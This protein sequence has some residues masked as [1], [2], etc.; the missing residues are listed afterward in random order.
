MSLLLG[1]QTVERARQSLIDQEI[2]RVNRTIDDLQVVTSLLNTDVRLMVGLENVQSL[3]AA[4]A[5]DADAQTLDR[6]REETAQDFLALA[7]T[8]LFYDQLR[9]VDVQGNELVRVEADAVGAEPYVVTQLDNIAQTVHFRA[10]IGLPEGN[11]Y[12]SD[13]EITRE[14]PQR[15]IVLKNGR[16][17]PVVRYSTPV[18]ALSPTTNARRAVGIVLINI[19]ADELFRA[20][21]PNDPGVEQ[22]YLLNRDGYFLYHSTKPEL[23]FGFEPGI[24]ELGLN[25]VGG[26]ATTIRAVLPDYAPAY[27]QAEAGLKSLTARLDGTDYLSY[28]ARVRPEGAPESYY[29][30]LI[31]LRDQSALFAPLQTTIAAVVASLFL[32]GLIAASVV[33]LIARQISR[34][35]AEISEKARQMASGNM[36][37]LVS[38]ETASR[39][40]EFGELGRSLNTMTSRLRELV[41]TLEAR[42]QARTAD[43]ETSAE[44][45]AAANRIRDL[46]DLISLTTNLIR[47][48]FD[49]YYVQIYLLDRERKFAVLRDGTGYVGRRLISQ[50]HKLPLDGRSL[51]ANTVRT[52]KGVVVQDTKSD[53]NFLPNSLLPETRAELTVP[54]K[55][56]GQIIGVLDIQHNQANAFD[57]ATV[58]LFETL[59]AQLAVTFENVKLYEDAQRRAA[60]LATVAEV[61]LAASSNLD[62]K[63]LLRTVVKLTRDNFNLYHAHIYL[64]DEAREWLNLAAGSGEAGIAMLERGHRIALSTE[65]SLV[66][67]AARTKEGVVSNDVTQEPDFLPNPLLPLTRSEMAIPLVVNN[68]VIGVL[69]VQS[70]LVNRFTEEDVQVKTTLANQI[71]IALNN[72]RAFDLVARSQQTLQESENRLAAIASNFPNGALVMYDH[73]FRY[74]L[75]DGAGLEEAGL[76]KEGM[77]GKTIYEVFPPEVAEIVKMTYEAALRGQETR[78]EIPFRDLI[79]ETVNVPVRDEQGNIIAGL[80]ITQN[81]TARRRAE[82]EQTLLYQASRDLTQADEPQAVLQIVVNFA[83]QYGISSANTYYIE[84]DELAKPIWAEVV[85]A[86]PTDRQTAI[87]VGTRYFLPELDLSRLWMSAP[88]R[89]L[90]ISNTQEDERVDSNSRQIYADF[91]IYA[92]VIMPLYS[93]GRWIGVI[94][95]DWN[96]PHSFSEREQRVYTALHQQTISVMDAIRSAGASRKRA[97]E[98]AALVE[99]SARA[100]RI[101]DPRELVRDVAQVTADAFKLYHLHIYLYEP[102]L[103]SLLLVAGTGQAPCRFVDRDYRVS[104]SQDELVTHCVRTGQAIVNNNVAASPDYVPNANLQATQSVLAI[105]MFVGKQLIGVLEAHADRVNAFTQQD[106]RIKTA[107]ADQIAIAIRNAQLYAE[108]QRRARE[109]ETVAA[110]S[111]EASTNLNINKLLMDVSNLTKERFSLYHAHIY[112]LDAK[113]KM[114]VLAA[115]AGEAGKQMVANKH[116]IPLNKENSLVARAAR[117]RRGVIA[118]DVSQEPDFL[119]NPL[120]P[121]TRSEMAIPMLVGDELIGVLDVQSDQINRFNEE[122]VQV[123]T[124]LAAQIAVAVQNARLFK[125]VG[126][127]RHAI[128][129]HAIVAITDQTGKITYVNNRFEQI[130]KYSRA[131]LLGQDHRIINSGYH[132]KEFFRDMWVTIANGKVWHGQIR[133]RAKD[134]TF[135][136]V[137][138]TI[139]P[140]L[141]NEGKPYQYVSIRSDITAQKIS[142]EQMLRRAREL[143]AAAFIST[144]T[145]VQMDVDEL[146]WVLVNQVKDTFQRYHAHIYLLDELGDY[147]LLAAGAGE[148]GRQLAEV[149]HRIS[150]LNHNSFVARVA[151]TREGAFINDVTK[152]PNFMAN[153]LLPDTKSELA[154]PISY[155]DKLLGVL[156]VQDNRTD[157]F[158]EIDVQVK[159][160]LANQIAIALQNARNY[161]QMQ[162]RL[163]DLRLN[164]Q[165]A[166]FIRQSGD[167][168]TLAENVAQTLAQNFQA[169]NVVLSLYDRGE[170]VWRGFVGFGQ[171]MDNATARQF[172]DPDVRYPHAMEALRT[173]RVIAVDHAASYPNFPLDILEAI[174]IQ[175]VAAVP[176]IV[177]D[178]PYGVFFLNYNRQA[179][180][181]QPEEIALLQSVANQVSIGIER[182][183]ASTEVTRARYRAEKLAAINADLSHAATEE[184]IVA[185][186]GRQFASDDLLISLA[187]VTVQEEDR[188]RFVRTMAAWRGFGITHDDPS[189]GGDFDV[190]NYP[191]VNL[192]MRNPDRPL[193]VST[194]TIEPTAENYLILEMMKQLNVDRSVVLPLKAGQQWL[195]VLSLNWSKS[196][197]ISDDDIQ[198][199]EQLLG[200][201]TSVVASRRAALETRKRAAELETIARVS[202]ATTTILDEDE[203]L[204]AVADLTKESFG[205]Y[206][207]HIYLLSE[208][209]KTLEL[210]AGA[211]E[212]GRIMLERH[213]SIPLNREHSLVARAARTRQV[214][215]SNDVTQEPDFLPNPLLPETRS[216]M[217]VP[218]IVGDEL[219]GVLDV[220]ASVIN[221][222]T[223]QDA[224]IKTTLADQ[225]AI[226]VRNAEAF[227]RER[228]TVARLREVDRLK[229]EF[230]ANMSHELR[231]PLNSIIGYSEVLMDGVDGDLPEEAV[232]DVQA[233]HSSGRHLLGLINEILDMAK[234]EAG[235]MTLTPS[236][237][238][239]VELL[240]GI[241]RESQVLVKDKPIELRLEVQEDV[242]QMG[243]VNGDRLRLRQ[244]VLNLLSNAVKFTERGQIVVR[245]G[246]HGGS[247]RVEVE[248]TGIGIDESA[249]EVIFERF[250]QADGSSTR[251]AGG[252]GLGLAITRQLVQMHGGEIGV[253]SQLGV[254]STFWFTLPLVSSR[255][256]QDREA[257]TK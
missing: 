118:N 249:L 32:M 247:L 193:I 61:A 16:V 148:V 91:N 66:A 225:V 135:Y 156:D 92:T 93:A 130:S 177:N 15:E 242:S 227:E 120:L 36:D 34:P 102:Q 202:A 131:E 81:I 1:S 133:N 224:Q 111:T 151:R 20:L 248:D 56:E 9:F 212:A 128:D 104:L 84:V 67:R 48:R 137:E 253:R 255:E 5:S 82:E 23:T 185:A 86:W 88:N 22:T 204:Q 217:A 40:D 153:P 171:D 58:R 76:S 55:V 146:L 44:I 226:A 152:A 215:I 112:L 50:G 162:Q 115:G 209:G 254:G 173:R 141:D 113:E 134:G 52:Q 95:L 3:A 12:V 214:V 106:V 216:E 161:Q 87:A 43:L 27:F 79:Y 196:H 114:L 119:P 85:A 96:E 68:E 186:I 147:L 47:D 167:V 121:E 187:Y 220:Q 51:I 38:S 174:G 183:L 150:M 157:A 19:F 49:F 8:R 136:W 64:L 103:D 101:L 78:R 72:A 164:A 206:H 139:V 207:A 154:I 77:E 62:I 105:P 181:F 176:L 6:L 41:A 190:K 71:A 89:P 238:D 163:R 97:E 192:W 28:Y 142:E 46:N 182:V 69:D 107:L 31:T 189:L 240:S 229:Q 198:I 42:V 166:E 194:E 244:I 256:T 211:G 124:T 197:Q 201:L 53:P 117:S 237:T 122:D 83:S 188:P 35:V 127:V 233:I 170:R 208:D 109:L 63:T 218:M 222:F 33:A 129:E 54:L 4:L 200:T 228:K 74:L 251:R 10:T 17:V 184:E 125:E 116:R 221:R 98:L 213:H 60:E 160:T 145:A 75:V 180:K 13:V 99:V 70:E 195:G 257:V 2:L 219:I 165:I 18:Y 143:E 14:G 169:D 234:I 29:W 26:E 11:I 159:T 175:S 21:I 155:G 241:V 178:A 25:F 45:A 140:F 236:P 179:H 168:E 158:D 73:N 39:Q 191:L 232:E 205:L 138:T 100:A 245:C 90:F 59:A 230:L 132:S 37:Q 231:T 24:A 65:H 7:R 30:T 223:A 123:K 144:I 235:Q 239:I 94:T 210:A 126:D 172:V 246:A 199:F 243:Q 252:T 57:E 110:V 80:T 149:G 203:L 108:S 250:R